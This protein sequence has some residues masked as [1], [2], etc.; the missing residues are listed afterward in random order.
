MFNL[1]RLVSATVKVPAIEVVDHERFA[2]ETINK[3]RGRV[4]RARGGPNVTAQVSIR[5]SHEAADLEAVR[6]ELRC[7]SNGTVPAA[8]QAVALRGLLVEPVRLIPITRQLG[9]PGTRTHALLGIFLTETLTTPWLLR[10]LLHTTAIGKGGVENISG[11]DC[12]W[13]PTTEKQLLELER[14]FQSADP[15]SRSVI[16]PG[17]DWPR[18]V[19]W[20]GGSRG[21]PASLPD[22]WRLRILSVGAVRGFEIETIEQP[23]RRISEVLRKIRQ[24]RPQIMLVWDPY[25]RGTADVIRDE[26]ANSNE[27]GV[28]IRI[29]ETGFDD[30]VLLAR[31]ELDEV[32]ANWSVADAPPDAATAFPRPSGG[33]ERYYSKLH[34]SGKGDIMRRVDDCGHNQ[35]DSTNKAPRAWQGIAYMESVTPQMLFLCKRCSHHRWRARF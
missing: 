17:P 13:F 8:I 4:L 18:R 32:L 7:P 30:A 23:Y 5:L 28:V 3:I 20:V 11:L 1:T 31:L 34:G 25:V 9:G 26:L 33:E 19:F 29:N 2:Y 12:D 16:V 6:T 22:D 15:R 24:E 35:W 21:E 27:D 10:T 14:I